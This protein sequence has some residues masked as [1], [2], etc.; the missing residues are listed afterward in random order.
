MSSRGK[1]CASTMGA[2]FHM[3]TT[4]IEGAPI[5]AQMWDT[6]GQEIYADMCKAYYRGCATAS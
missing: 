2:D 6:A 1:A 4:V 3:Y 5:I